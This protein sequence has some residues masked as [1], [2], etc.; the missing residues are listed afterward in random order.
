MSVS[1]RWSGALA[2]A[3]LAMLAL[4]ADAQR[5]SMPASRPQVMPATGGAPATGGPNI[6]GTGNAAQQ[7]PSNLYGYNNPAPPGGYGTNGPA[8]AGAPAFDPYALSTAPNYNPYMAGSA[9]M[10]NTPSY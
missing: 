9:G 5:S 1:L 7:L 3:V 10:S 6:G 4:Q 8:A 2:A